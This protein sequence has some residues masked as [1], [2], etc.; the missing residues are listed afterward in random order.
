MEVNRSRSKTLTLEPVEVSSPGGDLLR[1]DVGESG[2]DAKQQRDLRMTTSDEF[3][4]AAAK[5]YEAGTVDR[6]LW[7]RAV[8]QCR[9]DPS[10]VIAAYL[11]ARA[12]ELQ[13]RR[14]PDDRSSEPGEARSIA[15]T[16]QA[17]PNA[18]SVAQIASTFF[19][20]VPASPV[21]RKLVL[22]A[23]AV[24]ALACAVA[25]LYMMV[26]PSGREPDQSRTADVTAPSSDRSAATP[27]SV[28]PAVTNPAS[29]VIP[30]QV[31]A[32]L[33]ATVQQLKDAGNWNVLVLYAAEWTRQEP[34]NS[35]AWRELSGGY[36]RLRQYNDALD[37]A[38]KA[39][40]LAPTDVIAWRNLGQ[41]NLAVDRLPEAAY[42]F[43]K[44][45]ALSPD[46]AGALCG[47]AAVAQ[48]Q[49]LPKGGDTMA[50]RV[51]TSD[52]GCLGLA[53]T[54]ITV[55]PAGVS[56]VRKVVSSTGR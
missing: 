31:K 14:K 49:S 50:T 3:L 48:R 6:A 25:I 15:A 18:R 46:D 13:S 40:Q 26:S 35:A 27:A 43:D 9:N 19:P 11:R 29:K 1:P 12:T 51:A 21:K 8:D 4:A 36:A 20:G 56:S 33:P 37:A 45:L 23:A 47:V 30:D 5:E 42:A 24:A 28:R 34:G 16:T 54:E 55:A 39:A 38:T 53:A 44:A 22:S 32:A 52:S 2:A 7:R 10:L 17:D 41:I